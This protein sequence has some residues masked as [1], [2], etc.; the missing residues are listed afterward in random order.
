MTSVAVRPEAATTSGY[1]RRLPAGVWAIAGVTGLVAAWAVIAFVSLSFTAGA[2]GLLLAGAVG[3][4]DAK[5]VT[6]SRFEVSPDGVLL[7]FWH[8]TKLHEPKAI[9]V[10]H[11]VRNGRFSL[12]RRGRK[13]TLVHFRETDASAV[14]AFVIAG[15]EILSR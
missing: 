3:W 1:V 9:V 7:G 12:R 2:L 14:R 15:V 10:R 13:R 8:R 11:N 5:F 6:P 4:F